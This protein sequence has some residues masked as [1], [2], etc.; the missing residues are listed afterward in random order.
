MLKASKLHTHPW[1]MTATVI[2]GSLVNRRY[3]AYRRDAGRFFE[4]E[5]RCGQ[6][7]GLCGQPVPVQLTEEAPEEYVSGDTY[8]QGYA[9]IHESQP[10]PG[11][12]TLIERHV[13]DGGNP[14]FAYVYYMRVDD[15]GTAEPRPATT[16]EI[17]TITSRALEGF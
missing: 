9:E 11:T 16:E 5:I 10:D 7:G 4:Q 1:D 12:V 2:S 13:P 14:D 15:W 3:K 6:G 8:E 17:R